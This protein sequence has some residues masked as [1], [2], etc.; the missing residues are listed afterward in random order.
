M[1]GTR[2][3]VQHAELAQQFHP[4][5]PERV[6]ADGG[7][8]VNMALEMASRAAKPD[9]RPAEAQP[10]APLEKKTSPLVFNFR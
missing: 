4:N 3:F 10:P 5:T 2:N 8:Q 7:N 6:E 1:N 9:C